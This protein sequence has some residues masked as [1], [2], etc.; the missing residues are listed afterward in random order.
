M[1]SR[2]LRGN[3]ETR[4]REGGYLQLSSAQLLLR[5]KEQRARE[6]RTPML[7]R[8]QQATL[9]HGGDAAGDEFTD[10][11]HANLGAGCLVG[12]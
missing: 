5:A 10:R 9:V 12:W 2:S 3:R 6:A 1:I 8:Q 11:A 7:A 4:S